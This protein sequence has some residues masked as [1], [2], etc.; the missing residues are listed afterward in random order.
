LT[1]PETF[2][3][4]KVQQQYSA[5]QVNDKVIIFD[6]SNMSIYFDS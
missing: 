2:V 3:A 5:L 6:K 1:V 4:E